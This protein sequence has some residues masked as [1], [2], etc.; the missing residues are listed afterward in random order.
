MTITFALLSLESLSAWEMITMASLIV[1]PL[2]AYI[3]QQMTKSKARLWEQVEQVKTGLTIAEKDIT[4]LSYKI[5]A[6]ENA[7]QNNVTA[8]DIKKDIDDLK[9]KIEQKIDKSKQEYIS[10]LKTL[11]LSYKGSA[12]P[13]GK[14]AR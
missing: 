2:L 8:I 4:I 11:H 13:P 1:F 6:L 3:W 14:D 9:E 5:T 12:A 7:A 10:I